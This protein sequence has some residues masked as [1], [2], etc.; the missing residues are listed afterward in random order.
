MPFKSKD[1]V[2]S[3][4]KTFFAPAAARHGETAADLLKE[5]A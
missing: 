4:G 1:G 3:I 2:F 5:I